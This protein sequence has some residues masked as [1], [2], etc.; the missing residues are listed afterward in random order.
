MLAITL[1][2]HNASYGCALDHAAEWLLVSYEKISKRVYETKKK[3]MAD[4]RFC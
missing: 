2:D 1:L 4:T 3:E